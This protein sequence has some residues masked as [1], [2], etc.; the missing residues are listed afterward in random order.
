MEKQY[1]IF[2]K[3]KNNYLNVSSERIAYRKLG[4]PKATPLVM[5]VHLGATLDNWDPKLLDLPRVGASKG[6][7]AVTI[8]K[9]AKQALA[10]IKALELKEIDLLGKGFSCVVM[11]YA[12]EGRDF[13][14][15]N[16]DPTKEVV[17]AFPNPL[18]DLAKTIALLRQNAATWALDAAKVN[19]VG[20]S[21]GGNLIGQLGVYWDT[22]WLEEL[23]GKSKTL[24]APNSLCIAYGAT[25]MAKQPLLK[26]FEQLDHATLGVDKSQKRA[27][28]ANVLDKINE[29]TPPTFIWHTTKDAIVPVKTALKLGLNLEENGVPYEMH[30]YQNGPHGLA[31]ADQRT[32]GSAKHAKSST[33]VATWTKLYCNWLAENGLAF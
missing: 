1:L 8:S 20:F 33:Q 31:L 21:A 3:E 15:K 26:G 11:E 17:S 25:L 10:I 29:K 13:Y 12:T 6:K 5:L 22:V 30:I 27:D 7:V 24:Y 16:F 14:T 19:L 23:V 2:N 4:K 32:D 28:L 9:M 18:I